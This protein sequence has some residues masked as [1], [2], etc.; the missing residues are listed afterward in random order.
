MFAISINILLET[1]WGLGTVQ[2]R[3]GEMCQC[4]R[5]LAPVCLSYMHSRVL[6]EFDWIEILAKHCLT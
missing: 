6:S 5:A 1:L 2:G 3:F 4:A